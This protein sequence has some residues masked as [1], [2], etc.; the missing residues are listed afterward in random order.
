MGNIRE[1]ISPSDWD[2]AWAVLHTLRPDLSREAWNDRR[3]ALGKSGYRLFGL[4]AEGALAC[5]AGISL[6]PH[7]RLLKDLWVQDLATLEG[8]RARGHGAAMMRYLEALAE[9]EGFAR[10]CV[11]TLLTNTRAQNFYENHLGYERYAVFYRRELQTS[12][13]QQSEVGRDN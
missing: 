11:Y 6:H 5:V 1:F 13:T 10:L 12:V 8:E 9:R 3:V 7:P 2:S 4:T